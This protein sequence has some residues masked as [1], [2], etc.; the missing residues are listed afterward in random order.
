MFRQAIGATVLGCAA[1]GALHGQATTGDSTANAAVR[2]KVPS[3]STH[4]ARGH[5]F[6]Q[7]KPYGSEAEF[8]PLTEFLNEGFDMLRDNGYDRHIFRRN[9]GIGAGA[10]AG[11]L[12]HADRTYRFYG[13]RRA[14][15][16]E[17]LPLSY[18]NN[19]TGGEGWETKWSLH[20]LGSGMVSARLVEWFQQHEI[21]HP[22]LWSALTMGASHYMNEILENGGRK[23]P[24][25]DA[26]TDF[27]IFN[28]GGFVLFQ[29]E[30]VQRLFADHVEYTNWPRQ[31]TYVP[32]SQTLENTGQ[33][34]VMRGTL[35]RTSRVRWL[36]TF[37]LSTLFGLS[38]PEGNGYAL[39]AGVGKDAIAT[40][41]T[42]QRT[43]ARTA[44]LTTKESL[45][46]DRNGS[47]LA[48]LDFGGT[49]HDA[50]TTINIYPGALASMPWLPGAWMESLRAGGVRFGVVSRIGVGLG[51]GPKY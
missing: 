37:G 8:N 18:T 28:P 22:V 3:D 43:G 31:P 34:F 9:Y 45:F 5:R 40:P 35:P 39:S 36:C 24:N 11:S 46:L 12:L 15:R 7:G 17:I 38:V 30:R 42:D 23:V 14:L 33:E 51:V 13:Y 29:S 2:A 16:N 10:V 32:A 49:P 26:T 50:K 41:V 1:F 20:L 44:T 4:L 48:L 25:E 19:G 47:L 6:Y 21:G 27:L